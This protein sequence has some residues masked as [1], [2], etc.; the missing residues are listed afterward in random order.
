MYSGAYEELVRIRV[1]PVAAESGT[2]GETVE[3]EKG[4]GMG[5]GSEIGVWVR[6]V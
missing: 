3:G 1:E 2:D 6:M 4:V 5:C